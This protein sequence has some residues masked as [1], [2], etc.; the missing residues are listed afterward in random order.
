[1]LEDG[2]DHR[3]KSKQANDKLNEILKDNF[4]LCRN[5]IKASREVVDEL[6]VELQKFDVLVEG[7][8]KVGAP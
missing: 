8:Y 1:M 2:E 7:K 6:K 3:W 4:D 5:I